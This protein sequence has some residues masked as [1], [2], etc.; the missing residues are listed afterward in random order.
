[1]RKTRALPFT[2]LKRQA[3]LL[4]PELLAMPARGLEMILITLETGN[5]LVNVSLAQHEQR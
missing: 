3:G 1:M 5:K 2:E 4:I